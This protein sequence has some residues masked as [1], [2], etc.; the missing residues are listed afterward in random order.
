VKHLSADI[1]PE[2][3]T[4]GSKVNQDRPLK[5]SNVMTET[6]TKTADGFQEIAEKGIAQTKAN[7]DKARAANEE[8][9]DLLK[10]SL[11]T[12]AKG[13]TDYHLKFIEIARANTNTAFDYAH[14]MLAVKSVPEFVELST[15]HARKQ[16]EVMTAQTK[17]LAALAQ[18]MTTDITEPLKTGV[19]KA[20]SNRTA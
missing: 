6:K 2:P 11:A 20:F 3:R 12:A 7:F 18:K 16:F 9:T 4:A 19:T 15:V 17:E 14:Q 13:A 8:G 1:P 5:G 10:N